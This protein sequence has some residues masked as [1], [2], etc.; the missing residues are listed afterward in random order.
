MKLDHRCCFGDIWAHELVSL[1]WGIMR[2]PWDHRNANHHG[3]SKEES[4]SVRRNRLMGQVNVLCVQGPAMLAADRDVVPEPIIAK[5]TRSPA[6]LAHW[7]E[8]NKIIVKLSAEEATATI[9]SFINEFTL[10]FNPRAPLFC[11]RDFPLNLPP[12]LRPTPKLPRQTQ[13]KRD[14]PGEAWT[15]LSNAEH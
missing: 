15:G 4:N 12:P 5:A 7:L 13:P 14:R 2:A 3:G 10:S 8:R 6:A 11:P 9:A 1:L